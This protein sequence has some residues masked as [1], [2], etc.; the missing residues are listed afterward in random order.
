MTRGEDCGGDCVGGGCGGVGSTEEKFPL[1]RRVLGVV[2]FE[3]LSDAPLDRGPYLVRVVLRAPLLREPLLERLL[4]GRNDVPRLA[5]E[6]EPRGGRPLID[7]P[8]VR[9]SAGTLSRVWRVNLLGRGGDQRPSEARVRTWCGS[10]GTQQIAGP[11]PGQDVRERGACRA[12]RGGPAFEEGGE[13]HGPALAGGSGAGPRDGPGD[14]PGVIAE[15]GTGQWFSC[16]GQQINVRSTLCKASIRIVR[17][18]C[19][20]LNIDS[21]RWPA[22]NVGDCRRECT[23]MQRQER[24]P[25]RLWEYPMLRGGRAK[26][27]PVRLI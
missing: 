24:R 17:M 22:G 8:D 26:M 16:R 5:E 19:V 4:R 18:H 25:G 14:G 27:A 9:H 20:C 6:D 3:C 11:P 12:R 2:C 1:T 10:P 7:G 21:R 23:E 13:G 15:H